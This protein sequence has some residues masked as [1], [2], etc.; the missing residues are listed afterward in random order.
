MLLLPGPM[1]EEAEAELDEHG[2]QDQEA[3]EL[4]GGCEFLRLRRT[5]QPQ[6][7]GLRTTCF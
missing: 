6:L 7:T 3:Y 1:M 4:V 2:D 5:C